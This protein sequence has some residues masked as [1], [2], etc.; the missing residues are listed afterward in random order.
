MYIKELLEGVEV[1]A[2]KNAFNFDVKSLSCKSNEENE[3]GVYFCLKG[4][5]VD[6]HDFCLEAEK[7]GAKCLVVENFVDSNLMQVKVNN[8]RKTMAL[9]AGNF[10]EIKKTKMKFV[11]ITG[12]NG[13]T[14]TTFLLK[15]YLSK[16]I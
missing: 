16:L 2:I 12:T 14:T 11:G 10:Y 1:L 8:S 15:A 6:G 9:M 5:N 7:L 13:K 3:N 4:T